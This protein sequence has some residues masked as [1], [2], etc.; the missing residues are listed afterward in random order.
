MKEFFVGYDYGMG[1]MW[2]FIWA[3][4][5]EEIGNK[6]PLIPI[7][8]RVPDEMFMPN[9]NAPGYSPEMRLKA[10]SDKDQ[11]IE[12]LRKRGSYPIEDIPSTVHEVLTG[13]GFHEFIVEAQNGK[14]N[15]FYMIIAYNKE[16][17]LWRYPTVQVHGDIPAWQKRHH[18]EFKKFQL[19]NRYHIQDIPN[20]I[21]EILL[22]SS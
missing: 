1:G 3:N 6:Y 4:S 16:E 18:E 7:W 13:K 9:E 12:N 8:E 17:I 10:K 21:H 20:P 11:L 19:K 14:N 15:L 2:F 22:G 5:M